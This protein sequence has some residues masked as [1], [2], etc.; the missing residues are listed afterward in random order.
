M[1]NVN[2]DTQTTKIVEKISAAVVGVTNLQTRSDFWT[3]DE[4][5]EAGTGSGVIYKKDKDYAYI[6]TNHHVVEGADLL[7]VVLKDDTNLEAELLGSDL[8]RPC[9]IKST[10]Q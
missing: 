10:C 1:V 9:R 8:F 7:E 6:V 5:S 3:Q 4:S 2:V